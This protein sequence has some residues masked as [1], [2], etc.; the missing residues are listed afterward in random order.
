MPRIARLLA[1]VHHVQE[2][3]D[4][5]QVRGFAEI[6]RRGQITCAH[7]SQ[8]ARL[9]SCSVLAEGVITLWVYGR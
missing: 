6:A 4:S 9:L 5:G 8:I 3:V 7:T 2:L 1:Q